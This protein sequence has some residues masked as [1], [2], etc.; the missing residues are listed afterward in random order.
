MLGQGFKIATVFEVSN[1]I[2]DAFVEIGISTLDGFC[3]WQPS[4][5]SMKN[6]PCLNLKTGLHEIVVGS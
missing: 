6:N 4:R 3:A 1:Q 5:A 2:E